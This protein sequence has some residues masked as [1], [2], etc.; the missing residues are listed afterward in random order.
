MASPRIVSEIMSNQVITLFEEDN[1]TGI[2]EGMTHFKFRH[3]PVVDGKKLVGLVTHRDLLRVAAS[4]FESGGAT[5]TARLNERV[6]VRDIMQRDVVTVTP[7]TTIVD[8]AKLM[9]EKRVSCVPVLS[10]ER[11][12]VG[13]VTEADYV[14]LV[15]QLLES[16]S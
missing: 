14:K 2:E 16:P 13:L 12:L 6:F 8:A 9:R 1:L 10:P 4:A 7:E 15:L 3:L 11:E 5:K